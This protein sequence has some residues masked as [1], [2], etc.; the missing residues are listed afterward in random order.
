MS[1][2]KTEP[3]TKDQILSRFRIQFDFDY[4]GDK[5]KTMDQTQ[6]TQPDMSLTVRQLLENHTRG[7]NSEVQ[8][9]KPLYFDIEVPIIK[10]ITDVFEYKEHLKE[11]LSLTQE[12]I[13]EEVAES[14]SKLE[15][16]KIKKQLLQNK[17]A[18]GQESEK[19]EKETEETQN[20][21]F[22]NH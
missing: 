17:R 21:S 4:R 15:E 3:T 12:F 13:D 7:V 9:K 2:K 1:K 5:G 16:E 18:N 8:S 19:K 20:P 22:N 10:D 11:K 6:K 14:K